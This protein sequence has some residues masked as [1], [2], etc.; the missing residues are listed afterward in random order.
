[1]HLITITNKLTKKQV[2]REYLT[3]KDAHKSAEAFR[4]LGFKVKEG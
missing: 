3:K 2:V 4:A 1:M